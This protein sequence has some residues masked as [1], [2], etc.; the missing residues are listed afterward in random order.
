MSRREK[1]K[2]RSFTRGEFIGASAAA[3]VGAVACATPGGTVVQPGPGTGPLPDKVCD[4]KGSTD[5]AIGVRHITFLWSQVIPRV[6]AAYWGNITVGPLPPPDL[7]AIPKG[8]DLTPLIPE[9]IEFLKGSDG[10]VQFMTNMEGLEDYWSDSTSRIPPVIFRGRGGYDF[11]LSDDG[12]DVFWPAFDKGNYNTPLENL[13]WYYTIRET[14]RPVL[15]TPGVGSQH[16]MP[17]K[18]GASQLRDLGLA[19]AVANDTV[20]S[21]P[22]DNCPVEREQIERELEAL[23]LPLSE[24]LREGREEAVTA[25]QAALHRY[26]TG[27]LLHLKPNPDVLGALHQ[28]MEGWSEAGLR[29]NAEGQAAAW[30]RTEQKV[31]VMDWV[32]E[33]PDVCT[34][35]TDGEILCELV[36]GRCWHL[37]GSVFRGILEQF[38]RIVAHRWL[39]QINGGLVPANAMSPPVIDRAVRDLLETDLPPDM[40]IDQVDF[41]NEPDGF[42]KSASS[43]GPPPDYPELVVTN[44]GLNFPLVQPPTI[45]GDVTT[46]LTAC[47]GDIVHGR[48]GNPVFT[49]S[50]R[51]I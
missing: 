48:A 46:Q 19:Q 24:E 40:L 31:L 28:A 21:P 45:S 27:Y 38:P 39:H 26:L 22:S 32:L 16:I 20:I 25:R 50:L 34:P 4:P 8:T 6:S 47:L 3:G 33:N 51:S 11:Y 35:P 18:T 49:D 5:W 13:L 37:E 2:A 7:G 12:I 41:A 17:G 42:F 29:G 44:R 14:G 30:L 10:S 43:V 9:W 15:G 36:K 1:K 23:F